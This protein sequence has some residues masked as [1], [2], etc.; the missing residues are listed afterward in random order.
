MGQPMIKKIKNEQL[1][2]ELN[3]KFI[4][5]KGRLS[6][7]KAIKLFEAM[8]KEAQALGIFPPEDP[9]EGIEVDIR[10]ARILNSCLKPSSKK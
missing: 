1:L 6:Y 7:E 8:W 10:I 3:D 4:S 2:K 9:M 5:G